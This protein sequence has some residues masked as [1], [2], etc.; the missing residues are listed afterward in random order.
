MI[1]RTAHTLLVMVLSCWAGLA[2]G[3]MRFNLQ[4]QKTALGHTVYDLHNAIVL[5]CLIIFIVVFGAMLYAIWK[6]RKSVGHQ[7]AHF[8]ENTTVEVIWTVIPFLILLGMAY[9]ATKTL[10]AQRDTSSPDLTIKVTGYQ[11]KWQ[12]EYLQ[13]NISFFSML[14]TP[15]AQIENIEEKGENYLLEVDNEVVVP[16]GKKVRILLTAGDVLHAWYVPA[17][18]VKQDAIPGFVRDTWFRAEEPGVY[19]GQCAELCGKEHGY[20]PVVVR[21][22]T[23]QEYDEWV[24]QQQAEQGTAAA[25]T[26]TTDAAPETPQ[27]PAAEDAGAAAPAAAAGG[28]GAEVYA[29]SCGMCHETGLAGAPKIGDK[30]AWAPRSAKGLD[31]LYGHAIG[32]F[33]MM[34]PKGG[35]LALSDAQVK[36]AV[37]HLLAQSR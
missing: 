14:A 8:H 31:V 33:N 34:P 24:A 30:A 19:R 4:D 21:V 36:A 1:R 25:A 12:Y 11:W 35:N 22:V 37:D 5:I 32:G 26:A 13:E 28:D 2:F 29:Q 10:L 7:A 6:H 18:A 15:R 9:P 17:L 23:A 16:V 27:A 20:M 3:E